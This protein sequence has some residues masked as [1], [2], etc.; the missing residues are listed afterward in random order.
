M[1]STTAALS[2]DQTRRPRRAL[3]RAGAVLAGLLSIV[4]LSTAADAV[5]HATGVYPPFPEIMAD[6]LFLLATAYRVVFGVAGSWLAARLAP[7]HPMRHALALGAVG[8]VISVAGA[9]AMWQYGPA[10]YSLAIVAIS[11]P[12]AWA[13]G[14]LHAARSGSR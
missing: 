14:R 6:G 9:A 12:C 3:R 5:L 4:V 2:L 7:D 10:W 13:G 11:F 8:T 1:S